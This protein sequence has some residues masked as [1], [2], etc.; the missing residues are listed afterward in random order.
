MGRRS[1]GGKET[2]IFRSDTTMMIRFLLLTVDRFLLK[3]S[4]YGS[5]EFSTGGTSNQV[6]YFGTVTTDPAM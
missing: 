3:S 2:S 6:S 4:I 5:P 1:C